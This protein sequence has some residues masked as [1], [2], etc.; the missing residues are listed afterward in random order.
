MITDELN[1]DGLVGPTHH[2]AGLSPGNIASTTNALTSAT[3]QAA[4]LQGL[5]KMRFLY[6][7]GLKQAVL[8]PHQ[9]PNLSLLEQLGFT[10][11]P[12]HQVNQAHRLA[13]QLLSA[14]YSAS[15]MWAANAATV[16][17]SLDTSDHRVHFTAAN[18]VS[19]LH[20]HQEADFCK[21]LLEKIF[22]NTDYF[23]HHPILPRSAATSD[24]GAANHTRLCHSHSTPGINLF[25]YG[26]WGMGNSSNEPRH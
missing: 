25:V 26:K 2:Y 12:I 13:P 9:R 23:F 1:L 11:K 4:A 6:R 10:G 18:L 7:L 15:S 21:I 24:E 3:P 8:P 20:R 5:E 22:N 16:S 14:C 17:A 19:N